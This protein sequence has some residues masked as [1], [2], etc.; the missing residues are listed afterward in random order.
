MNAPTSLLPLVEAD[1][2]MVLTDGAKFAAFLEAVRV[3]SAKAGVD[4]STAKGRDAIKSAAY[5]IV[6]SK[7][8][9]DATGKTLNESA[10]E[11]I[12]K[13]DAARREIR[14]KMDALAAEV[15]QPLTDWEEVEKARVDRCKAVLERLQSA[16]AFDVG[17]QSD[18]VA[19]RLAEVEATVID[20]S[21]EDF[22]QAGHNLKAAA[23]AALTSALERMRKEEADRAELAALRAAEDERQAREAAERA[24]REHAERAAQA[25]KAEE[26]R[27][28]S[29]AKAAEESARAQVERE[30][31]EARAAQQRQHDE[32]IAAERRRA[33][34]AEAAQKAEAE[35]I[36][37]EEARRAAEAQAAA[38][39]QA[40][41]EAD[42]E[43]KSKVMG[44]AKDALVALGIP[45]AKAKSV[46]LAIKAGEIPNVSIRF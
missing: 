10:R 41:R 45:E 27:I 24:E 39:A 1:P 7:T 15:R 35:R 19:A 22:E 8:A 2:S 37:R 6:R 25:A 16:A 28:A 12:N 14:E 30:A 34:Q 33:E 21:F 40:A 20:A 13:V 9:I 17:A 46:V 38:A 43:H 5:K 26:E 29:A 18:Q 4:V 11:Q 3:E 32:A 31:A 42:I 36:A 23:V 44:A